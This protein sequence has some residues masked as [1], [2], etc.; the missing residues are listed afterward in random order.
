[1]S[2]VTFDVD[3]FGTIKGATD[4]TNSVKNLGRSLDSVEKD[5]RVIAG[6]MSSLGLTSVKALEGVHNSIRGISEEANAQ[7][8]LL[9]LLGITAKSVYQ[10]MAIDNQK[11][12]IVARGYLETTSALNALMRDTDSKNRYI[13]SQKR[14]NGE[15][16][17]AELSTKELTASTSRLGT[18]Q[19]RTANAAKINYDTQKYLATATERTDAKVTKLTADYVQATTVK[20]RDAAITKVLIAGEN[21]LSTAAAKVDVTLEKQNQQMR[22][23]SD[24]KAKAAANNKILLDGLQKV[25]TAEARQ[26]VQQ[27]QLTK[28]IELTSS[29]RGREILEQR[30][31]L[32]ALKA[33]EKAQLD[34]SAAKSRRA[35]ETARLRRELAF[36]HTEEA[37]SQAVLR[38]S[39]KEQ[40]AALISTTESHKR[41]NQQLRVGAQLTAAMRASLAGFQTSIGMYTSS[42][43]VAASAMYALSRA[44][45]STI[46]TGAEYQASMARTQAIMSNSLPM[47]LQ[48]A[49]F[50]AMDMQIRAMGKSSQFTATE[51]AAAVTEL[52]QAGLSAGQAMTALRPTLDLAIIGQLNMARAADH[53]TNIMMIFG[54]EARDLSDIVDVMAKA[55]TNSNTN[56]DQLANALTYAGPAAETMGVSME[57]TTAAIAALANAGFKASRAGTALRRLFVNLSSPTDKGKKLLDGFGVTVTDLTGKTRELTDILSQLNRGMEDLTDTEKL[58]AIKDIFGVYA[59][60]PI[61]ALLAQEEALARMERSFR[62]AGGEAEKMRT[63][64]EAALQFDF[65]TALSAFQDVQLAVFDRVGDRL[66]ELT[67]KTAEWLSSLTVEDSEGIAK[68]D[69]Y[70]DRISAII[71]VSAAA[72]GAWA[73]NKSLNLVSTYSKGAATSLT[74]FSGAMTKANISSKALSVSLTQAGGASSLASTAF[75]R[76]TGALAT[77]SRGLVATGVAVR[78]VVSSFVPLAL[79]F[80]VAYEAYQLF[81]GPKGEDRLEEKRQQVLRYAES[82]HKVKENIELAAA[83]DSRKAAEMQLSVLSDATSLFEAEKAKWETIRDKALAEGFDASRAEDE[84]RDF[85]FRI[86]STKESVED[87]NRELKGLR[88]STPSED[89]QGIL[90][91]LERINDL[92]RQAYEHEKNASALGQSEWGAEQQLQRRNRLLQDA[93]QL[94][95]GVASALRTETEAQKSVAAALQDQA[96]YLREGR[97]AYI[98]KGEAA[99]MSDFEKHLEMERQLLENTEKLTQAQKEYAGTSIAS[100]QATQDLDALIKR[101]IEL[102]EATHLSRIKLGDFAE[103]IRDLEEQLRV[104]NLS[105]EERHA[106]N[107]KRLDEII[108][109]RLQNVGAMMMENLTAEESLIAQETAIA[110]MKEQLSLVNSINSYN[111]G[112]SRRGGGTPKDEEAETIK[113][114][115]SA[116]ESLRAK[117]DQIA[118]AQRDMEKSLEALNL[119]RDKDGLSLED[120]SKAIQQLK[121]DYYDLTLAQNENYQTI[122]RLQDSYMKSSIQQQV[123]DLAALEKAYEGVTDRGEEYFRLREK[124]LKSAR[125]SDLPRIEAPEASGPFSEFIGASIKHSEGLRGYDT[126]SE[127]A[128]TNWQMGGLDAGSEFQ[129]KIDK[130][131]ALHAEM[132]MNE[133]EHLQAMQRIGDE[134]GQKMLQVNAAYS[135]GVKTIADNRREYEEQSNRLVMAS[136]AGSLSSMMGMLA[137][138]A[139]EGST[140]QKIAFAAQKALAVA[141]ILLHTHVAASRAPADAGPILG[142]S[143]AS[144]IMA[145]GYASAGLVGALAIGNLGGSKSS[146][147]SDFA[148]AYDKGGYIPTGKYGI[149]GEYGPEI[150]NGPAHVTGREATARK[151]GGGEQHITI[152]PEINI[153]YNSEGGQDPN[154]S[155]EDARMLGQS[156]K[157]VVL[158]T[159]KNELRPNGMLYRR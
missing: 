136:M 92:R 68:L 113:K 126:A 51:V 22:M 80:Y 143:L 158:D 70:L 141:Q 26:I 147:G 39:I 76:T 64:I 114:A 71:R 97:E 151:L 48:T 16:H 21:D 19:V 61:A 3:F 30:R 25:S 28:E 24:A 2:G 45:R 137:D 72:G 90:T 98:A 53:A 111:R 29:A 50:S 56:V 128:I 23:S 59:A 138:A 55:V 27:A 96:T 58:S 47:E 149:V 105:E 34:D 65:K 84:I 110:L 157:L 135:D 44:I 6:R 4:A 79:G 118:I 37:R 132:E 83:A 159:I 18:E 93:Y 145:Q 119:L 73:I 142:M 82:Y 36:L 140:T 43:I 144:A 31:Q 66:Q 87:L 85:Q 102:E 14:I 54:K 125:P 78:A 10:G 130:Q 108:D 49:A 115:R 123:D 15:L 75:I 11:A 40:S 20:G 46:T 9:S 101:Q 94:Q 5:A 131:L 121:S 148:G 103:T 129:E 63:Q 134:Y 124:I 106:E 122:K 99:A 153:E 91:T 107:K 116:Y 41:N 100:P 74:A 62:H 86:D 150:V 52:G 38:Q 8:E 104:Q 33:S 60:S 81:V 77:L 133:E 57:S 156:V 13:E 120:Y 117:Y 139:E 155:Q 35:E 12:D 32:A 7:K 154:R 146:S 89:A 42:T 88:V 127:T 67:I 152:A 112:G 17:K 1:M 109:L 69:D 95:M